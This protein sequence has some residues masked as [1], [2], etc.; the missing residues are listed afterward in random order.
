MLDAILT[1][2]LIGCLSLHNAKLEMVTQLPSFAMLA[3]QLIVYNPGFLSMTWAML[4]ISAPASNSPQLVKPQLDPLD[5]SEQANDKV[6][7]EIVKVV[8]ANW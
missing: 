4:I 7:D 6:F 2:L 5:D 3:N 8:I 1:W